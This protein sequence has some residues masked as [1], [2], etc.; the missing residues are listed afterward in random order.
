[1]K[2]IKTHLRQPG[3][4][5][6]WE[7]EQ[8]YNGLDVT[9]THEVF[10]A[11]HNQ[12]DAY[13]AATYTFSRA[14]Q[15]PVLEMRL[16]GLLV[17]EAQ[18][19]KVLNIYF[20]KLE[21]LRTNLERL[22]LD[23]LGMEK[24]NWNSPADLKELFYNHLKIPAVRSKGRVSTD[25]NALEKLHGYHIARPF[26][27]YLLAMRELGKRISFLR[28]ATDSDNRMRT[29][30]NIAGTNTGR[31][32]SA[33]S[34]FGTGSNLQNVEELLR[35]IFIADPGHKFAKFD[36][37]SGESYIVGALEWNLFR[38]G[39][40]LDAVES[41][42]IHTAVAKICWPKLGWTGDPTKDAKI[43]AQPYYKQFSYRFMCKKLGHGSNYLGRPAT[44][45]QSAHLPVEVVRDFQEEY[46]R[47][48]PAHKL[49]GD[50]TA[51]TLAKE[52][53]LISLMGRKRW[54]HGRRT[55]AST[56]REATAF[57]PQSSLVDI[58]NQAMLKIWQSNVATLM[59]Q[60]HD[61][62]VFQYPEASE[63]GVVENIQ[64]QLIVPVQLAHDRVLKIPYD[65]ETGWNK[66]SY[67]PTTN[68]MGLKKWAGSD[69]RKREKPL[70]ILDRKVY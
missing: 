59:T 67:D 20:D 37:K 14:L 46:F 17:D 30:Y 8:V 66:G 42:D 11:I 39:R 15:G 64:S 40:Y 25:A 54:F 4:L 68:P 63:V 6:D 31:F 69:L 19:A 52:G 22:A 10:T 3:T 41:G 16:R 13:T 1:M 44:L 57:N 70:G 48:F 2:I 23:G 21:G 65:A 60:E 32:S 36:A 5:S 38:D 9:V 43:A 24:F 7:E 26:V 18:R 53:H 27:N 29:S 34:E 51:R 33:S 50:W 55:E 61:A 12:L 49:W 35:T 28:T 45:A 47:A 62:L 58:V 56:I